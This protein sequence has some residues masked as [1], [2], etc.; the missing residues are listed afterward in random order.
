[1]QIVE[2]LAAEGRLLMTKG[3]AHNEFCVS[4]EDSEEEEENTERER[5]TRQ[6]GDLIGLALSLLSRS[7][8]IN[9]CL[10]P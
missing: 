9:G 6:M 10:F 3:G 8:S 5:D 2:I 1:M 4:L 7:G